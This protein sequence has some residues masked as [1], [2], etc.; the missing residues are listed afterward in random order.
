MLIAEAWLP[1]SS[2]RN[3]MPTPRHRAPSRRPHWIISL[4]LFVCI[5]VIALYV[6][7]P[8][9]YSA[10]YFLSSKV[11]GPFTEWLPPV[12][13]ARFYTDDEL[14]ARV[15]I[16]DILSVH[17][18]SKNPKIAFMFLTPGSLPFEKLWERFFLGH[19]DR[20]SIYVHASREQPAHVSPL[21]IDKEIHSE[22]VAWGKI[23]MVDA[24]KRL[25][26]NALQDKDNQHFVL[27]SESCV[28]LHNFD[29]VY[30]YLLGTNVSFVDCFEDP[31]PHGT[32]RYSE[33]MLPVIEKED[34]RKGA[35]WFSVKRQHAVLILAD[36]VYYTKFKLYCRP[37]ME[38]RNCYSDEHYLPTFFS[39]VDPT[40]IANWSVTHVDWSEGKW[41]PKAYRARDVTFEIFKSISSI[42][43]SIHVTS[44]S[45]KLIQRRPCLWNG[46]KRPCYLFARKFYPE[47]LDN[48]LHLF[49]NYTIV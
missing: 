32:G 22:K 12:R 28:P 27:L 47:S 20:F 7:P 1:D 4:L 25:L 33:H 29:Y 6:Y 2:D 10:C 3:I 24:E 21:F 39:M 37:G 35:Q 13:R 31:G 41:H 34:F 43:E 26:A 8:Q 5:A 23:S 30:N 16:S 45:K 38:G 14:F 46:M 36:N 18:E 49:S 40:G 44:D 17:V 42:D 48:L 9:R 19:E 15:V 11:C